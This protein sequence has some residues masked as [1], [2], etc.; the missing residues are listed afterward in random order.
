MDKKSLNIAI[1][2]RIKLARENMGWTQEE[3]AEKIDLSPQ[4]ISTIERG[5]AGASLETIIRLCEVLNVSSEWLLC[6]KRM[7][8]DS[9]K[10]ATKISSLSSDQL[11]ALDRV[12]DELLHLIKVTEKNACFIPEIYPDQML[13]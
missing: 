10:I 12:T 9:E 6:G 7:V 13:G 3:L 8:P 1:G 11:A 2:S 4:F 5:V